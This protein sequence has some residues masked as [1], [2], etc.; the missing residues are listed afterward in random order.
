[1]LLPSIVAAGENTIHLQC[2]CSNLLITEKTMRF[3]LAINK[4]LEQITLENLD[5][6][7]IEVSKGIFSPDKIIYKYGKNG[8]TI[9]VDRK[10]LNLSGEGGLGE[11]QGSCKVLKVKGRKI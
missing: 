3:T 4:E 11:V 9:I 8:R 7:T 10:T 2:E 6:Q 1:M 5:N